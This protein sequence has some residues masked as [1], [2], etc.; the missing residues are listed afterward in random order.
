MD[1]VSDPDSRISKVC[2]ETGLN[3][4]LREGTRPLK[5][6]MVSKHDIVMV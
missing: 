5:Y 1:E 2:K 3:V 6:G 4:T